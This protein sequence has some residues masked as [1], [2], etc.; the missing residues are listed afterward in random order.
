M[1]QIELTLQALS[2]ARA[3]GSLLVLPIVCHDSLPQPGPQGSQRRAV[4]LGELSAAEGED[5]AGQGRQVD[6]RSAPE[7]GMYPFQP[8]REIQTT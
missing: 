2:P 6:C 7:N 3:V 4:H 1:R 5:D 8:V